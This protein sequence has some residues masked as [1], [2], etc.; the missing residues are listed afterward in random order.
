MVTAVVKKDVQVLSNA[1]TK[2]FVKSL[3]NAKNDN[4]VEKAIEGALNALLETYY[5]KNKAYRN[6]TVKKSF[7]YN[8]DGVIT[9]SLDSALDGMG[10]ELKILV[11]AKKDMN[12]MDKKDR[13]TVLS[14]VVYYLKRFEQNADTIPN[15]VV[16]GDNDEVFT[17]PTSLLKKYLRRD[18]DWSIAPSSASVKNPELFNEL[19]ND[20]NIHPFVKIVDDDFDADHFC[21]RIDKYLND[22]EP[23]KLQI[24]TS[25]L[26]HIFADFAWRVFKGEKIVSNKAQIDIFIAGLKG[27]DDIYIHPKK[28]NVVVL[29]GKDHTCDS[30]AFSTF[31][32]YYDSNNYSLDELKAITEV[33]DTLIEE[34]DRRFSGDFWTPK[35]WVDQAHKMI[36]EQLGKDW[37]EKYIVWDPAAG[38]KNL[39]RDYYFEK[40][41]Y[42]ST[43][44]EEELSIASDYNKE[45][46]AFQ[47]DFLNDDIDLHN[48][49]D[50]DGLFDLSDAGL[51][52]QFKLPVDLI[53]HL[54]NNEPIVFLGNPP[55]GQ[56][57][58]Q[59]GAKK[60]GIATTE[61][62]KNMNGLGHA[63]MELYTQ[64]IY[65]VQLLAKA[66]NYTE[67]FFFFFFNKGFLT[68][69]NFSVFTNNLKEQFSYK[70]GFMLNAGEF[71]GTS[72]AWGII[73]SGWEIK[74]PGN[75]YDFQEEL[76]FK[77][78]E[79]NSLKTEIKE[80]S[81]W[82]SLTVNKGNSISD[83][84]NTT[85]L[86][87]QFDIEAPTTKNGFDKPNS[88]SIRV[89]MNKE[90][91]GYLHNNGNNVQY[92]DKYLGVYSLGFSGA[93]GKVIT[94]NNFD[95][96]ATVFSIRRSVQE[97]IAEQKL[98]WVRDK[99]VFRK[100]SEELANNQ[101][102]INDC[103]IYSLIDRQS[104]QTSLRNYEYNGTSYRVINEFFPFEKQFIKELAIENNN[105]IIEEDL[106]PDNHK[107]ERFVQQWL[108]DKALSDEASTL[109]TTVK[110]IYEQSFK[111]RKDYEK[112]DKYNLNSWDAGWKQL[113]IMCFSTFADSE[114]KQDTELQELYVKFKE[115]RKALGMKIAALAENDGII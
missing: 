92:S 86:L 11:E 13:S 81:E 25:R 37:K 26:E 39:T 105:R 31:W 27:S 10:S 94:K 88:K 41:L 72:S 8:T 99:D 20:K 35:I 51:S 111:Y 52:A 56:A 63:K 29:N 47:Y 112:N 33:A 79:S 115:Q 21:G 71:Q 89:R 48:L 54:R 70:D 43:L 12:Y 3:N 108:K 69:P 42:S 80:L 15:V 38:S 64:F 100:P 34:F 6:H 84:L 110:E 114:A 36:E 65:R 40:G 46:V 95:K 2:G 83:Y 17:L 53:Q 76:V 68:S 28:P 61:I 91:I 104:N 107:E 9:V 82:S 103:V 113:Y 32:N 14:Q 59:D 109:M 18:Y 19:L 102:F 4:D 7:P 96:A 97:K 5:T 67:D 30:D 45:G 93:N 22:E 101:E 77:V 23:E 74:N 90:W 62:A 1:E 60:G 66:F 50:N 24:T 73:F 85:S 57:T 98:L 16:C 87:N 55:Y 58:D 106:T 78:L 75:S 49:L 44:F